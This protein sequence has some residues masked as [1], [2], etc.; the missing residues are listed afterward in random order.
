MTTSDIRSEYEQ[1]LSE[2]RE[3]LA[4]TNQRTGNEHRQ[5][6]RLNVQSAD[7]W[8]SNAPEFAL[9]DMSATGMAIRSSTPMLPGEIIHIS[10]GD[11]L[12]ID[13]EVI[14]SRMDRAPDDYT[15][16][17][18]RIQCR[19]LEALGGLELLV[20]TVRAS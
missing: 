20:R 11:S 3:E 9:V 16:G 7:L 13:A 14:A 15:A 10:L 17:E 19:F 8:I 5:H 12:T 18:F 1:I 4:V 2:Y 6:P